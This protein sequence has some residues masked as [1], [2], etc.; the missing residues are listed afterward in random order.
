MKIMEIMLL[1]HYVNLK[2]A[3]EK[4]EYVDEVWDLLQKAYEL[5]GGFKSAN[6]KQHLIDDSSLWKLVRRDGKIVAANLYKDAFG[7]KMIACATDG[8]VKGK[9]DLKKIKSDDL[10]LQ[11]A[12][13]E[14]S[15]KV[16]SLFLKL[17]AV[18]LS[19]K[20]AAKLT[21]KEI[22]GYDVDGIHYTRLIGGEP[23]S[24]V[25]FGFPKMTDEIRSELA[26]RDVLVK[27]LE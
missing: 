16:E 26:T 17:G 24:K 23:H 3:D 18:P 11:R 8:S 27:N 1:E 7:R 5:A 21:K 20:F 2:T 15:G 22:L 4:K 25:I 12:W 13:G 19:N 6:S 14:A 10:K 9:Q